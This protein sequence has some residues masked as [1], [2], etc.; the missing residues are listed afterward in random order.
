[1]SVVSIPPSV[2]KKA[3]DSCGKESRYFVISGDYRCFQN[4]IA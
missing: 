4:V 2:R 3:L 1:M